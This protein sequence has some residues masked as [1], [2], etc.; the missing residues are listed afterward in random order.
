M[1]VPSPVPQ[2]P[3]AYSMD[4]PQLLLRLWR[5]SCAWKSLRKAGQSEASRLQALWGVDR[6]NPLLQL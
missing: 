6:N 1:C 5:M 4:I 2:L 3:P